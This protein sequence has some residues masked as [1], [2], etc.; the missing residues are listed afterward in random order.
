MRMSAL[1]RGMET[2]KDDMQI[3]KSVRVGKRKYHV[4]KV[5][6]RGTVIGKCYP[7]M[8]WIELRGDD[9][10]V[11]W[12]EL[13]HAILHDMGVACWNDEK[14]VIA[15]SKRLDQAIKTARF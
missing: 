4:N 5:K 11:F 13:T 6:M 2:Q 1:I 14:F 3:P 10:Y 15:F 9:P 12:H 7:A 8:G